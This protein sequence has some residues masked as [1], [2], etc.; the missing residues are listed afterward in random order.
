MGLIG[1]TAL[2]TLIALL[3]FCLASLGFHALLKQITLALGLPPTSKIPGSSLL[4]ILL[5]FF[6]KKLLKLNFPV[7]FSRSRIIDAPMHVV[8]NAVY[9]RETD[10][11]Y[12]AGL[13][14]ITADLKNNKR[15]R[16]TFSKLLMDIDQ[17]RP[18]YFHIHL[19]DVHTN[20]YFSYSYEYPISPKPL[21]DS[22]VRSERTLE[23]VP[24]G[25][26][27][28]V[29]EHLKG[30]GLFMFFMFLF[31]HPCKDALRQLASYCEGT[32]DTS[33]AGKMFARMK[34]REAGQRSTDTDVLVMGA[35]AIAVS[36]FVLF[37][38][39]WV[40]FKFLAVTA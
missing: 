8:W 4:V 13:D 37:S 20:K 10:N 35:T 3:L 38:L 24:G 1:K 5:I 17:S 16:F 40:I 9:P 29:T 11:Y 28:T 19:Q 27:V 15:F 12:L 7:K 22:V 36:T 14:K 31:R 21:M 25:I 23:R 26:K 18:H 2:W 30:M 34:A 33:W 6:P 39:L 32:P